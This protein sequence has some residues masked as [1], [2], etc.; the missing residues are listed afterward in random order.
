MEDIVASVKRVT[1]IMGDISRSSSAQDREIQ[2]VN[3]AVANL[4]EMTQQNAALVEQS[5]AAAQSMREQ[6]QVL[7]T[8]VAMFKLTDSSGDI[9]RLAHTQTLL[10]M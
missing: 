10:A 3:A 4:D 8:L 9:P 7:T 6:A 1:D 2:E 5:A